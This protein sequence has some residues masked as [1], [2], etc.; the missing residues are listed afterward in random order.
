[1]L[2]VL[3]TSISSILGIIG[4]LAIIVSAITEV[5][6][7]V[8]PD[9]FPAKVVVII[10]SFIITLAF[11]LLFCEITVKMIVFGIIGSFIVSFISMYGW[12]T[13]KEIIKRFKYTEI[14]N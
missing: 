13:F 11:V 12:D 9:S 2:S 1:M 5:L 14:N 3:G 4:I 6:K 7:K 8:I 10:T